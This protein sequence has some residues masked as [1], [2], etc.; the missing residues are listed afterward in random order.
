MQDAI[1]LA[2]LFALAGCSIVAEVEP[3]ECRSHRVCD[4]LNDLAQPPSYFPTPDGCR[5]WQCSGAVVVDAFDPDADPLDV[6]LSPGA[7]VFRARDLD[8]DGF[9][10]AACGGESPDCNDTDPT[11]FPGA[12]EVCDGRDNDCDGGDGP[13]RID[14]GVLPALSADPVVVTD[15]ATTGAGLTGHREGGDLRLLVASSESPVAEIQAGAF[16]TREL[17]LVAEEVRPNLTSDARIHFLGPALE[18]GCWTR[19]TLADVEA[20]C[21]VVGACADEGATAIERC[22]NTG[23][24]C[25]PYQRRANCV[26]SQAATAAI[27]D[28]TITAVVDRT[29]GHLHVGEVREDAIRLLGPPHRSALFGGAD[30]AIE[31]GFEVGEVGDL[32][33][34]GGG[35]SGVL[36]WTT[37]T[38][39]VPGDARW[40]SVLRRAEGVGSWLSAPD[41]GLASTLGDDVTALAVVR[42]EGEAL[43]FTA[44][45]SELVAWAIPEIGAPPITAA[46]RDLWVTD[47]Y[48]ASAT[49]PAAPTATERWRIGTGGFDRIAVARASDGRVGVFASA[50]CGDASLVFAELGAS[51]F[52]RIEGIAMGDL[53]VL[54]DAARDEWVLAWAVAGGVQVTRVDVRGVHPRATLPTGAISRGPFLYA[55]EDGV[56]AAFA[57]SGDLEDHPL[58]CAR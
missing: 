6:V 23:G 28:A 7:C 46:E 9:L 55:S 15:L 43:V 10:A 37:T 4:E 45:A 47:P 2:T 39:C 13:G 5:R 58:N 22:I 1:T 17:P 27:G 12:E 14:D 38:D 41:V 48:G 19:R 52:T 16:S 54:H 8:G 25:L 57:R 53:D 44:T 36:A 20:E 30:L 32:R 40:L 42:G 34:A 49:V 29:S 31:E 33:L 3:T 56:R 18:P 24:R 50:G 26:P 35:T 11:V 21:A 51:E